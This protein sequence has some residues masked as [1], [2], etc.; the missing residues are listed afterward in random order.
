MIGE[1][2]MQNQLYNITNYFRASIAAK[3]SIDFKKENYQ[4]FFWNEL[5]NGQLSQQVL[6]GLN[7]NGENSNEFME[8]IIV[9]KTLGSIFDGQ[10]KVNTKVESLTGVYFIPALLS[11][12]GKLHKPEKKLPWIAREFLRPIVEDDL[13]VGNLSEYDKF[14]GENVHR[15]E[16]SENW[17]DYFALCK[18]L[19]ERSTNIPLEVLNIND[20]KFLP[21]MFIFLDTSIMATFNILKLYDDILAMDSNENALPLY[22]NFM[23]KQLNKIEPLKKSDER[24]AK[25]HNGQMG[26]EYGLSPSQRECMIHFNEMEHGEILAVNGPPGTGKTTLLQSLVANMIVDAAYNKQP[27][28]TI[29]A[30]S[31]NNQAVTNIIESFGKIN[32]VRKDKLI[33]QRWINGVN[34]FAVYFPSKSKEKEGIEKGFH[35]TNSKGQGFYDEVESDSNLESSEKTFKEKATNYFKYKFVSLKEIEQYIHMKLSEIIDG[36]NGLLTLYHQFFDKFGEGKTVQEKV[37]EIEVELNNQNLSFEK[38]QT[39]LNEWRSFYNELPWY[40][41]LFQFIKPIHMKIQQKVDVFIKIEEDF[42]K[43]GTNFKDIINIYTEKI[44]AI[45]SNI[46]KN[47]ELLMYLENTQNEIEKYLSRYEQNKVLN[48]LLSVED[49]IDITYR[50]DAF[51]L[52]V[53]YFECKWLQAKRLTKKQQGLEFENVVIQRFANLSMITP[54]YVMT[55]YQLAKQFKVNNG[56]QNYLYNKIDLLI[57]DEAGQVTPEIAACSF[58]LAKKAVVVGDVYQ[59]EPVWNIS[60]SLDVSL[61]T[62]ANVIQKPKEFEELEELG[63]NSSQSSVM[64][65]AMKSSIYEKFGNR[66]L[67]L[68]EHRRCYDEIIEYCN[69]LIYE[70]NLEPMRGSGDNDKKGVLKKYSIPYIGH[71][72]I[73]SEQSEKSNGSRYNKIEADKIG[74]WIKENFETLTQIYQVD[75][76][77]DKKKEIIGIIT[78]FKA[79][80]KKIKDALPKELKHLVDVG[81]VHTFQGGERKIIIFSTVYGA[82]D[83]CFF[84]DN[85]KSLMNVAVSRAK[86]SFLIFGDLNCLSESHTNPSGLIRKYA[87]NFN[88]EILTKEKQ[89]I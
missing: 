65:V 19:Y 66:G 37:K 45:R 57:V 24:L 25:K 39:R 73:N 3:V 4:E 34:S 58:A 23:K 54:C 72:Q 20:M 82:K 18:K 1:S 38:M 85:N 49:F 21:N 43:S 71:F 50:Y 32:V 61:A 59:I 13:A 75:N 30:A 52:A 27:A 55:F 2:R 80:V 42:I 41:R 29:V 47:K 33:E 35:V 89:E 60:R 88:G 64:K 74:Q 7:L 11:S 40:Y 62:G 86:D 9:A 79:Q 84:I 10:T 14:L 63:L 70:G 22:E 15:F 5:Q 68:S 69:E 6:K 12:D 31:T 67:F 56:S 28:P 8:V 36:K 53:H 17:A 77:T 48:T 83:G 76:D 16:K 26:G 51:W 46:Q 87:S 78:P 81:T 44:I